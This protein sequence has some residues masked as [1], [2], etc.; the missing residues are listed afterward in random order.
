MQKWAYAPTISGFY[1]YREKIL[2]SSFDLSPNNTAGLTLS[3]PIISGG[4]RTAQL[5]QAK[6]EYEKI[7]RNKELLGEQLELQNR[8]LMYEL[9]MLS[10]II[11]C[12]KKM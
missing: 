2:R 5:S 1:S 12:K 10:I 9:K 8:Q 7:N 3:L 6:I 4:T 11:R